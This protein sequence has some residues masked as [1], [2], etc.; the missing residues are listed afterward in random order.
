MQ[1]QNYHLLPRP[2]QA[3]FLNTLKHQWFWKHGNRGQNENVKKIFNPV[4]L[5]KY[6][7]LPLV[8]IL[9]RPIFRIK[10]RHYFQPEMSL[11]SWTILSLLTH[12]LPSK[13]IV[14]P[15]HFPQVIYVSSFSSVPSSST[16][17]SQSK[18]DDNFFNFTHPPDEEKTNYSFT[19][20]SPPNR[21]KVHLAWD[22]CFWFH[23]HSLCQYTFP[24]S[25]FLIFTA[26]CIPPSP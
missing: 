10:R 7:K 6:R 15:Q 1:N 16:P 9:W 17:V 3:E 21:R 20:L 5:H 14:D 8:P 4:V 26:A 24:F 23:S 2:R 12:L 25:L 19:P 22:Q 18:E 13:S 11:Q